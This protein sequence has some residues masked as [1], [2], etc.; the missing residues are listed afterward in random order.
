MMMFSQLVDQS[1]AILGRLEI[2]FHM[3]QRSRFRGQ[4]QNG[5]EVGVILPRGMV[6]RHGQ[7]LAAESG[8]VIEVCAAAEKL[9]LVK[10]DQALELA[11]LCYHLGNRHIELQIETHQ[12]R[13]LQDSVIDNMVQ[14][15]GLS[16]E[17]IVDR[18]EPEVAHFSHHQHSH[19]DD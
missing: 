18:F 10:T 16:V 7:L 1:S 6:L 2:P 4:L 12:L 5:E 17:H 9:S 8:E 19:T 14:Q 13:Y 3:R 11:R 15:L